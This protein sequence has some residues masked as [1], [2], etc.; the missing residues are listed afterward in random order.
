MSEP[1]FDYDSAKELTIPRSRRVD[2][3][4][5]RS[6][7]RLSLQA[8]RIECC[9]MA[10]EVLGAAFGTRRILCD[11]VMVYDSEVA[12]LKDVV[13]CAK[14]FERDCRTPDNAA[15]LTGFRLYEAHWK[16]RRRC[17]RLWREAGLRHTLH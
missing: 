6:R 14:I 2:L 16:L 3:H 5:L 13:C 9:V 17:T 10:G 7:F 8:R 11:V 15:L 1:N 4:W 12:E